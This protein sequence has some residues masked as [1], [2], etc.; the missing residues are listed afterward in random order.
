[1]LEGGLEAAIWR[2]PAKD[3][4][5]SAGPLSVGLAARVSVVPP[6]PRVDVHDRAAVGSRAGY[7]RARV[8]LR[9]LACRPRW[10]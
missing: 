8:D 9:E 6:V 1:M 7:K 3:R 4:S 5:S 2:P 10:Q